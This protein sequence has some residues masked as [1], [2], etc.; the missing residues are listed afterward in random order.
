MSGFPI[1]EIAIL[2]RLFIPPEKVPTRAL[3]TDSK[4]T[5]CNLC[6]YWL[7]T[8][9]IAENISK[10]SRAVSSGHCISNYGQIPISLRIWSLFAFISKFEINT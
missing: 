2:S 3:A 9:F 5:S 1:P 7:G 4:S 10:C 8:N 6:S